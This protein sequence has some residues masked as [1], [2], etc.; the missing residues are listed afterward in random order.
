M[1]TT[2]IRDGMVVTP[3][4]ARRLD[5]L[6]DGEAIA[7]LAHPGAAVG[8]T[9]EV[10]DASG[11]VVLP[12]AI[13]GHTHFTQDDPA[14]FETDPDEEEGFEMGGRGAAAGGVTTV[15]EMPQAR[16]STVDGATFRRKRE[17]AE[18]SAI[19]DF[20]LWG[21][22]VQGQAAAAIL[23]QA[24]EGAAGF[25]AFMC[26]S[27]PSFPGV[28]DAQLVLALRTLAGTPLMLGLHAENDALLRAGL[29]DMA[30]QGRK[31]PIA[32]AES[33][34]RIVEVEAVSRAI[35]LAE[36]VG[37][38]VHVVHMST[39]DAADVVAAAKQRGVAV[40][41]ETCPH[42]LTHDETDLRRLGPWARCAPPLRPRADVERLW[43]HIEAGT[44]DCITTDHCAFSHRSKLRG[45]KDIFAAPNGLPGV[46]T[47]VPA[48][49]TEGR[50]RGVSWER[51]AELIAA[52]PARLWHLAPRKGA[53]VPGADADLAFL[54]PRRPWT[55]EGAQLHHT[56]KW[57]Q[58]DG[59][60]LDA[61]VVR[62]MVRG[63]TV[64]D[65]DGEQFA[66]AGTGRFIRP[67]LPA[68]LP[69]PAAAAR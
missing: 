45:E 10:I 23:D 22:V 14:L 68:A 36:Q 20:A 25:K 15:V 11:L 35:V 42:Y 37:A 44:I 46:E 48:V 4:G 47:F 55:V 53:I 40:T 51:I 52:A 65:R 2:L 43:G 17:L 18:E 66:P 12:G 3:H 27:D 69:A 34:P 58:Y 13:D 1:K 9:A 39:G 59:M 16:P 67:T 6:I 30:R 24:A 19:V 33:R 31:D 38:R 29:A 28:D 8:R 56:H 5:L 57:T 7:A 61:T 60:T 62:T 64:F 41:C 63:R 26:D 49:V 54:D 50:R 32:H 21:G